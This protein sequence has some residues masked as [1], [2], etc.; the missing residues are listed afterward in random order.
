MHR[1]A[2]CFV[3]M[4]MNLQSDDLTG[5]IG[6]SRINLKYHQ[7]V[8]HCTS[9]QTV[10]IEAMAALGNFSKATPK[11]HQMLDASFPPEEPAPGTSA[12]S[13]LVS[14]FQ[15]LAQTVR[16]GFKDPWETCLCPWQ[17]LAASQR[18][19]LLLPGSFLPSLHSAPLKGCTVKRNH[20]K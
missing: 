11:T 9:C 3:C 8:H 19:A 4:G 12:T 17:R 13:T 5:C 10:L 7:E 1:H 15:P 18:T 6:C 14:G 2:N 16:A 20:T